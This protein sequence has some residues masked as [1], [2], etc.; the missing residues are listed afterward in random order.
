[1]DIYYVNGEFVEDEQAKIS[2]NDLSVIRGFG[3]FDFLRTY[4]GVPFHLDEHLIVLNVQ[5]VLLALNCLIPRRKSGK[6]SRKH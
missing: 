5:H 2:V 6:S 4:N 3:V 1:M